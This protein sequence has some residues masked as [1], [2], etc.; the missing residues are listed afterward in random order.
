MRELKDLP[1]IKGKTVFVRVDYNVPVVDGKV[2]DDFRITKSFQT[3][4]FL[5]EKGARIILASHI[6]GSSETLRPVYEYLKELYPLVFVKDY[7]PQG[8]EVVH[9][10]LDAGGIVLLENLRIYEGEKANDTMFA[11]YLSGFADYYVNEAFPAAHRSHASVVGIPKFIPGFAGSV[12]AEE[13]K[14]LSKVFHPEHPF[15]FILGGAKF[16]TK[17]PLVEKFYESADTMF[18]GGALANDFF[19]S[20]GVATGKSLLSAGEFHLERFQSDKLQIPTDVVVENTDGKI[21]KNIADVLAD[22]VISDVGEQSIKHLAYSIAEARCIVWN[23]P[24]GN[25]EKGFKEGTLALA[26]AIAE[27]GAQSIV[28]G[29]DTIASIKELTIEDKFT[30]ISTGGGAMLD[31]LAH[32]TLPGITA[33]DALPIS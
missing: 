19:K 15:L 12:F 29:G 14:N 6:E 31:F 2:G 26:K 11:A 24:L 16:E 33:L 17:L 13:I 28:G 22:D 23:G 3:I 30:F 7:F 27:S 20:R 25:Y 4:D 5:K 1:D 9:Q 21:T 10:Y 18:I 8:K 32:E